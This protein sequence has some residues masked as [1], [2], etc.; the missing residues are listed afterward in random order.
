MLH[1]WAFDGADVQGYTNKFTIIYKRYGEIKMIKSIIIIGV[2]LAA[3]FLGWNLGN[4]LGGKFKMKETR[5][6]MFL[7]YVATIACFAAAYS[8]GHLVYILD[9][10]GLL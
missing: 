10:A 8:V 5:R 2:T 9:N 7:T 4:F 6:Q 3:I 1:L